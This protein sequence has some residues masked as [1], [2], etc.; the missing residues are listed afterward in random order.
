MTRGMVDQRKWPNA[1][2]FV[3]A[4]CCVIGIGAVS[5]LHAA[6][7]VFTTAILPFE[8]GRDDAVADGNQALSSI[9][10]E[11]A[12]LLSTHLSGYEGVQLVERAELD[13]VLSELGLGIS[14]AVT[15]E[16][17]AQI[18]FL[19]GATVL[20]SGR[21][22]SVK[23]D[24]FLVAKIIGTETGR[25]YGETV[26]VP[27]RESYASA[28]EEL[29]RKV[30]H[31]IVSKGDTLR[32]PEDQAKDRLEQLKAMARGKRLPTVSVHITE[33]HVDREAIDPAA[34]VEVSHLLREVGFEILDEPHSRE[35]P[36]IEIT[37]EAFSEFGLRRGDL[38]SSKAR[39]EIKVVETASGRVIAVDR[40]YGAA[41]DLSDRLAG[42]QAIQRAATVIAERLIPTLLSAGSSQ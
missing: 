40:E 33:Q 4:V 24:L 10:A 34:E 25:V 38:V 11:V 28:V 30:A 26:S 13:K 32:A 37:G 2:Q 23:N 36:D 18:G 41:V 8:S 3:S 20:V 27:L 7:P 22:F 9:G 29:A 14:G 17:A 39:V 6:Q 42:K 15:P 19:T 21:A 1:R 5:T 31:T 16:T 12:A 35:T